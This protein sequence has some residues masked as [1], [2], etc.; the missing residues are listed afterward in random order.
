MTQTGIWRRRAA[1]IDQG[2][3]A[4]FA[5]L[6]FLLA[7]GLGLAACSF[8]PATT[9]IL[10]TK[11]KP[12][13]GPPVNPAGVPTGFSIFPVAF[14]DI[15]GWSADRQSDA[16]PV[17]LRS[18]SR[19]RKKSPDRAMG[20]RVEMGRLS[21][22]VRICDDAR[23]IRSG[24]EAE[25]QY[26]FESRFVAYRVSHNHGNTGLI[27]GYYEPDLQGSWTADVRYRF[28]LY[29]L[30]K[31]L[32]SSDLGS[33]D[34]KW[35]GEQI[36]GRMDDNRFVPYYSRA[37]IEQG[38]LSGRQLEI[39]WVDSAIDAFFLHIQGSGRVTLPDGTHVRLGYAGRNGRRYTAVGRELVASGIMSLED[40]TMPTI[41]AWMLANP[42]AAQ[43]LMR[44]N[45]S[46]VFFRVLRGDGP[47]GAQGTVLTP[48]RS[49]A[50]DRKYWPLGVPV[51]LDTTDTGT[52]PASPLRR[53][54]VAQD[55]G[56]AI[57]GAVRA[58]YFWGH[59]NTAGDKAGIM[60][61]RGRMYMLL[62][63]IAAINPPS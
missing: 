1:L 63:R 32:I 41:R 20:S 17:F 36:A 42:V 28:P 19:L 34:I 58:D 62:P 54:G 46:F 21:H 59:G 11:Q 57:K 12:L 43:A 6:L 2:F 45:K 23:I 30:P 44:K 3:R 7:C 38:A 60:K 50:V 25:A 24:N 13:S 48:G 9:N 10:V 33:F 14:K 5:C 22:W 51:W 56:S 37:E 35:K 47:V 61:S 8:P 31:D 40:V 26:F 49:I 16:L 52:H 27:T 55:T 4:R 39:V 53:L 15:P 29:A 18:C